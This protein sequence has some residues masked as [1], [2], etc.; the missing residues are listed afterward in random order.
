M[1]SKLT[2]I[3]LV[4]S[5]LYNVELIELI[6]EKEFNNY[7]I[8][9]ATTNKGFKNLVQ[10]YKP[11]I[12]LSNTIFS[13]FDGKTIFTTAKKLVPTT[14]FIFVSYPATKENMNFFFTNGLTD[15]VF[16]DNLSRLTTKIKKV[17][18]NTEMINDKRGFNDSSDSSV[19]ELKKNEYLYRALVENTEAIFSVVDENL[20]PI[21]RSPLLQKITGWTDEEIHGNYI[22]EIIHPEDRDLAYDFLEK[23]KN[24]PGQ[25]IEISFR[26]KFKN[27]NYYWFEGTGNNQL[28]D[29]K[30]KGII[31]KFTDIS[32]RKQMEM[33]LISNEARYR[34][35]FE[36]SMDAI[37]LCQSDGPILTAN[38]AACKMFKMTVDEI[39]SLNKEELIYKKDEKAKSLVRERINTGSAAGEVTFIRKDGI[40]F[41]AYTSTTKYVD[42][43]DRER[44]CLFIHDISDRLKSKV[45]LDN[46]THL[47]KETIKRLNKTLD[48]STD[49]ICT[50]DSEGKFVDVNAASLKIWGYTPDELKGTKFLDLVFNED[51][52]KTYTEDSRVKNGYELEFF[53]NRY[54]HKNGKIVPNI[55]SATWDPEDDLIFCIAKDITDKK[56]LEYGL[57]LE[58][59]RYQDLFEQAPF[60]M[61]ILKGPN[62]IFELANPPYMQLLSN[63]GKNDVIGKSVKEILPELESQGIFKLLDNVYQT[64]ESFSASEMLFQFDP[65]G[66]GAIVDM[67]IDVVYQAHHDDKGNID[68]VFFF[69]NDVTPQVASRKKVEESENKF[70]N[71]IQNLPVGIQ[72]CDAAGRILLFNKAA[73]AIW[74][75]EPEIGI[76]RYCGAFK[77]YS[78]DNQLI[79]LESSPMVSLLKDGI[80][81][82]G[83]V[84]VEEPNGNRKTIIADLVPFFDTNKNVTG[85]VNVMTDI[86]GKIAIEKAL[87]QSEKKFRQIFETA[88]E[89]I[90]LW[91]KN[92][93]ISLVNNKMRDLL[94]YEAED[95]SN[96]TIYHF[97][98]EEDKETTVNKLSRIIEGH[99]VSIEAK[100]ISK[101][102][103]EVWT[104]ISANPLFDD[105]NELKGTLAMFTDISE[106][107]RVALELERFNNELSI[108]ID[109]TQNRQAELINVNKELSDF[110]FA[111]DESCIVAITDQ[112][113]LI[114]HAND[115]F[116]KISKFTN[117]ELMGQDHRLC[118]SGYHSKEYM[119]DMW[120][121]IAK[122]NIWKGELKNKAKDGTEYWVASTIIPFLD[123]KGKP[124]QY[125]A[126]RFDITERKK[127]EINLE[128]QYKELVKTNT[129]LDRFVYSVSHDLRSPLTSILGLIN[130]IESETSEP[131]TIKHVVMIR[132]SVNRLDNF[133]KNI[134]NYSR[135]NR[136]SLKVE[137]TDL[138]KTITDVINS[139]VGNPQTTNI[140]FIIDIEEQQSFYTD[141]IRLNIIIENLLSNAIK[142]HR[143]QGT[144]NYIKISCFSNS[145]SLELS[146]SDNGIGI[147]H[148][149][150]NKI[151][152]MFYRLSSKTIGSGIGL[153]IVKDTV[154]MLDGRIS[155]NSE[156]NVGSTF[157]IMLKNLK[158]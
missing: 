136:M 41:D 108:Q 8:E 44:I 104:H 98:A 143:E 146:I 138:Q 30:L 149:H 120:K 117:E 126:T 48:A 76:D 66:N 67:Y 99:A 63:I 31:F 59:K 154:Q 37:L 58:K 70:K 118:S 135:N 65:H 106:S 122:G 49:V 1:N 20:N 35:I 133:I 2:K 152:E 39:I 43:I 88:Q 145:E 110:K 15:F 64:G 95:I 81:Q 128:L 123:K 85:A 125:V 91:D 140:N 73:V 96:K 79:P 127:A 130:F 10:W 155:I 157:N 13:D 109:L 144:N 23:L 131:D 141:Q 60:A 47:L 34:A 107:K 75:R 115:N 82:T 102:G 6:L 52:E 21:Y 103:R 139:F 14:P 71:L 129:E 11:D 114:T 93:N 151:F 100:F 25:I 121:T 97:L 16:K 5:F 112:K 80:P 12:I 7:H 68:G 22:F 150:H 3:V 156:L 46:T 83:T 134:L 33:E 119:K 24:N 105:D 113:G 32:K 147:D 132:E 61:G 94:E 19:E 9:V 56:T 38:R 87:K 84:I 18:N 69:T 142:Y 90:W 40:K 62:H 86:T 27:G 45:K 4:E 57:Q 158:P 124:Y 54:I 148:M 72:S 77:L 42:S 116:C 74:G 92:T 78:I 89:G 51:L 26:L 55:W 111:I 50:I 36:N 153:Y 53:E 28:L 101:T 137:Q 29:P 17:L